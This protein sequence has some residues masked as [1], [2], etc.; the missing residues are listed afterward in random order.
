MK[1]VRI[2]ILVPVYNVEQ[3]LPRCIE[4]VLTQ[5]F[6][7]WELILV[8]DGSPDKC[9]QICDEYATK[10]QRIKVIHKVN[11]GLNS[12]RFVGYKK[13]QGEYLVFMDA[14]DW[15][16]EGSL[17]HLYAAIESDGGFDVVKSVVERASGNNVKWI[18]HYSFE[19][20]I[21]E[22]EGKFFHVISSDNVSPYL[23]SG[24]YRKDLFSDEAFAYLEKYKISV[25]EDWIN[26]YFIAT[27]VKRVKFISIPTYAYFLNT[28]SMMGSS[29]Y[30][31]EYY[32]RI[33]KCMKEING[34][35][36]IHKPEGTTLASA[37]HDL[38]FFFIPEVPFN[39]EQFNQIQ[40]IILDGLKSREVKKTDINPYYLR[41]ISIGWLFHLY[42]I[43]Y[44]YAFLVLK[45]KGKKRKVLK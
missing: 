19:S 11:G 40:P 45:L 29:V 42:T 26:N 37:L 28:S 13:A 15:L 4:S 24:M 35:L 1:N 33:K 5:D 7:D 3:Y 6:Q 30:G 8:D 36:G 10:D 34:A 43:V 38:R 2:S 12:A 44:R 32:D 41:F 16:L 20:G 22:G 9:P 17:N 14:D 31:W 23:H 21:L 18:E 39:K 25:G 27:K